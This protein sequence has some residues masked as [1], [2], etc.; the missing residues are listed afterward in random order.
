MRSTWRTIDRELARDILLVCVAILLVGASFGA[1][2]VGAGYPVW[3]PMLMSV[4]VFAGGSQFMFIGIV[5][6]AGSPFAALAAGVL[7]NL[8]HLP[9]GFAL[10]DVLTG[11]LWK[12]MF[13]SY[14]LIDESV[15]FALAQRDP[16]QR[17]A[18]YWL[19]GVS[20]FT[21]WNIG[22]AVGALVAGVIPSTDVLGLDAAFPAVLL[23]LLLPSLRDRPVAVAALVGAVIAVLCLPIL[24]PGTSV[25]AAL[26]AVPLAALCRRSDGP[27]HDS[28]EGEQ[29]DALR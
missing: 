24:P 19:C 23:A 9:F 14:L 18:A 13:G 4:V 21:A 22:T 12:R 20:L 26:V 16:Q 2:T 29:E 28:H 8:R 25:L 7:V 10:G 3:L 15:A 11:P 5:A 17:R 1:I 27:A 6:A